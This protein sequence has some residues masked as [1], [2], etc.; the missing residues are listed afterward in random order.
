M[1][2]DKPDLYLDMSSADYFADPCPVP[3]LSQS[4]AK[5]L[6]AESPLHAWH[7]HPR[8][9]P[10]FRPDDPT[11]FDVGNVAHTLLIG[12]G[13]DIAVLD[14]DDW[15]TKDA[16][17]A[18]ES[19]AGHGKLAVLGKHFSKAERMVKAAREQLELRGLGHLFRDGNGEVCAAWREGNLW[20]RQLIDWLSPDRMI[21]ADYK[22]TQESAA[23]HALGR[24]MAA[25]GWPVQAAMGERGLDA[26][27][28]ET[29][30]RRR[31]LFIVQED[32][33]PYALNVV[34]I[35]EGVLSLGRKRLQIAVD[36]WQ[37][38]IEADRWPGYPLE[39]LRPQMPGWAE[40][41]WTAREVDHAERGSLADIGEVLNAG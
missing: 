10:D 16:K 18:R 15:R 30:G 34:E 33:Q 31:Y 22:T 5:V 41:E 14:F 29:A 4:V 24:K 9:N 20:F 19:A 7:A 11:K 28:P 39:I 13:K 1:R 2:I 21:F 25:D 37:R 23:P 3:S 6:L 32:W 27:L 35:S 26:L 8:L 17:I 36:I 12:R 38:C 40:T